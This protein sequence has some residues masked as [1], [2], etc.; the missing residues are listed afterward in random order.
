MLANKIITEHPLFSRFGRLGQQG[1]TLP[2]FVKEL[3]IEIDA[4]SHT[5]L[6][7]HGIT[8][9]G[10]IGV[11]NL[12]IIEESLITAGLTVAFNGCRNSKIILG[13]GKPFK[14]KI[15][16]RGRD[17]I[18]VSAGF[19][20]MGVSSDVRVWITGTESGTYFGNRV[21]SVS[22]TWINE[23][24]GRYMTVGDDSMIS[25]GITVRNH[26]SHGIID[27]NT[28]ELIN[29]SSDLC[30][31]QHCWIG[32]DAYIVRGINV[33]A[34][35]IIGARS[36]VTKDIPPQVAVAGVPARIVRE[37]VTWTRMSRPSQQ[38][39]TKVIEITRGLDQ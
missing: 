8:L 31:A 38:E 15:V 39:I 30:I 10:D 25:W 33:G 21:T 20:S 24:D 17:N 2:S 9:E 34:G 27:V 5:M 18:F 1:F 35:S 14:G 6:A 16:I 28:K 22:S 3:A 11:G 29:L 32:Q 13:A 7:K 26:D 19:E 4:D 36:T 12:I 23:G 37:N